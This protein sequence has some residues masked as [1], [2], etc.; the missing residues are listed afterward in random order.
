VLRRGGEEFAN[1]FADSDMRTAI[2]IIERARHNLQLAIREA[3]L[4]PFTSSFGV[5]RPSSPKAWTCCQA[6]PTLR[7]SKPSA[8]AA[9]GWSCSPRPISTTPCHVDCCTPAPTD[10]VNLA[11]HGYA[12]L[13][14]ARRVTSSDD[15][16]SSAS[17][18]LLI[19]RFSPLRLCRTPRRVLSYAHRREERA[20][21]SA[22]INNKVSNAMVIGIA[23][24]QNCRLMHL[25]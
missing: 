25:L 15:V 5:T 12:R 7:C 24:V 14:S 13:G 20:S 2:E 11:D 9:T 1:A 4:P 19:P 3:R 6:V 23:R 17:Q 8:A 16:L 22:P 18:I 10:V 21:V